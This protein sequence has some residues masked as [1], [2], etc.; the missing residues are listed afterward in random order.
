M[1]NHA[2][3]MWTEIAA[4]IETLL[5]SRSPDVEHVSSVLDA[6][7]QLERRGTTYD[8]YRGAV[9]AGPFREADFRLRR[10]GRAALLNLAADLQVRVP[11]DTDALALFGPR[12]DL[13]II[14]EVSPEGIVIQTFDFRGARVSLAFTT[15]SHILHGVTL[16]WGET[17]RTPA[18]HAK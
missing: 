7:L 13:Q 11:E 12:S 6:E 18:P 2:T 1:S 8:F 9:N 10:D 3:N 14:P 17:A 15:K 16:A 5:R 4:L